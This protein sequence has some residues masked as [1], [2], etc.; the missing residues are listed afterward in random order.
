MKSK[1]VRD[2]TRNE[3]MA[4]FKERIQVLELAVDDLKVDIEECPS[5]TDNDRDKLYDT[6]EEL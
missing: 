6:L 2:M 5:I 4:V 3:A 1:E